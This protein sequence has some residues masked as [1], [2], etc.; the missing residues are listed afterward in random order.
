M[1][2]RYW[3]C[4][5]RRRIQDSIGK[6]RVLTRSRIRDALF[7]IGVWLKGIDGAIEIASGVALFFVGPGF[8]ARVATF[9]TQDELSEDPR[10]FV[11]NHVLAFARHLSVGTEHFVA[12]YLLAHG[13]IKVLLVRSLLKN[14][15]WAYPVSILAFIGFVLYQ[16]Y[17]FS[18]TRS[19]GLIALSVFD[20]AV[21]WLIWLEYQAMRRHKS[22]SEILANFDR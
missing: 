18:F 17:R 12:Y 16:L 21:V 15:L 2:V 19:F 10:D 7:R 5:N 14:V 20:F 6:W 4:M 3:D 9:L 13:V 1:F 22:G 8:I 11:A